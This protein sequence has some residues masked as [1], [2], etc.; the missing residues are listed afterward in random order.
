MKRQGRQGRQRGGE[1][2]GSRSDPKSLR[3]GGPGVL[4]FPPFRSP[5]ALSQIEG[6][7][8]AGGAGDGAAGGGVAVGEDDDPA[9]ATDAA[10]ARAGR[11][12]RRA[13]RAA[14]APSW[15]R[16]EGPGRRLD[17]PSVPGIARCPPRPAHG[18]KY[19]SL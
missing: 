12:P 7:A 6:G 2:S 9:V 14:V 16:G 3:L 5:V 17:P 18:R 10:A 13:G 11:I 4:A 8:V 19:T 1:G 15:L